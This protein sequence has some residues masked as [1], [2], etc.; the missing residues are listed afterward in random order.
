MEA[1]ELDRS[2]GY[3]G[4]AALI[5]TVSFMRSGLLPVQQSLSPL[6]DLLVVVFH[7]RW[8]PL[9]IS[10]VQVLSEVQSLVRY[11]A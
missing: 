5:I 10:L 6:Q 3:I 8:T 11:R 4:V 7:V 9:D 1:G 2:H